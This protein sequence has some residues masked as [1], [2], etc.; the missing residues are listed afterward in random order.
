MTII[1]FGYID[2]TRLFAIPL[3]TD[4]LYQIFG[5]FVINSYLKLIFKGMKMYSLTCILKQ[6]KIKTK[7]M[8]DLF[9]VRYC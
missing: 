5:E 8:S 9:Q 3:S 7:I 1:M 4:P 2:K 6:K